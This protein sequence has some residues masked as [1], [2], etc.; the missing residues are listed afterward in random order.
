MVNTTGRTWHRVRFALELDIVRPDLDADADGI[1]SYN[2]LCPAEP[3]RFNGI[4]D[5]DGCPERGRVVT[6]PRDTEILQRV[7][8]KP[9]R[10]TLDKAG[11]ADIDRVVELLDRYPTLLVVDVEGHT[12]RLEP[13]AQALSEARARTVRDAL[14]AH[15]AEP[16][17]LVAVGRGSDTPHEGGKRELDRRVV[18]VVRKRG[19]EDAT[20]GAAQPPEVALLPDSAVQRTI[21]PPTR[22]GTAKHTTQGPGT[23]SGSDSGLVSA[24][25]DHELRVTF[26]RAPIAATRVPLWSPGE[27][28]LRGGVRLTNHTDAALPPGRIELVAA[29]GTA[30][31]G[32]GELAI[33][34]L[35]P[36]ET[37]MIGYA[38]AGK[39]SITRDVAERVHAGRIIALQVG[40]TTVE[41][42]LVRA[43]TFE[44]RGREV[45]F[46]LH[47]KGPTR[48]AVQLPAGTV[49]VGDA[50]WIPVAPGKL[51]VEEREIR[52]H[53]VR[54]LDAL[55]RETEPYLA[56]PT[57]PPA[58]AQGLRDAMALRTAL[59]AF[60]AR[61]P[62]HYAGRAKLRALLATLRLGP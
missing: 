11:A 38:S 61:E 30:L 46:V 3:E 18:F 42:Q 8:F 29:A 32:T 26:L 28:E 24:A 1:A 20:V 4:D 51:V 16:D 58:I 37:A 53:Q 49:D 41:K 45:I 27:P 23:V 33:A 50:W 48:I 21:R 47:K 10:A 59:L 34:P 15:G 31:L 35:E 9:G 36:G 54:L 6:P 56:D 2:D 57:L 22:R 44:N 14:I 13:R 12:D 25:P 17:R 39:A 19:D 5:D 55:P 52:R 60:T 40:F 43:T 7:L 62:E